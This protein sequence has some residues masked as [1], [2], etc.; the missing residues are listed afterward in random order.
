VHRLKLV[1]ADIRDCI[2]CFQ[3]LRT[4]S[5]SIH[6]DMEQIIPRMK[7]A[8]GFVTGASVRNGYFPAI[9]KRFYERITYILGFGRELR[10]KYVSAIG[11]VGM[12]SGK[13]HLGKLLTLRE[14]QTNVQDYL[15]F[16]T[17]IPAKLK[18]GDV[19]H[20]LEGLA[21]RLE[22]AMLPGT[23]SLSLRA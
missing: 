13:K 3:C 2:G 6:D 12:A 22:A 1:D 16:R 19:T 9:Y 4:G 7:E 15:F 23:V 14:F 17:G 5:C 8:E 10:G 18:A 20:Q 21:D 11:A